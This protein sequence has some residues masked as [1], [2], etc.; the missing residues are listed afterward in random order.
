MY[1][2]SENSWG[3]VAKIFHWLVA[4]LIIWQLFTGFNLSM[5]DFSPKK[6]VLIELHKIFGTFILIFILLRLCWR[7]YNTA[8]SNTN[9]PKFHRVIS[10]IVHNFLYAI[11]ILTTI[12]GTLMTQLGGF[13]VKLLGLI[14]IPQLIAENLDMYP[15]FK[16]FHYTLWMILLGTFVIHLIAG[17]YH[18]FSGDKYK[19]WQRMSF[20]TNKK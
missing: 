1:K 4:I 18:R 3:L 15:T 7:F 17:I 2:S 6:I 16:S 9:L 19:V 20:W 13:D 5:L 14:T 8:P 12:Q 10:T 11:V